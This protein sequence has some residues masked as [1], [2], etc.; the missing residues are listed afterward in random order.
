M[1]V[2]TVLLLSCLALGAAVAPATDYYVSPDGDDAH[3]GL[4]LATAKKTIQVAV[5]A[6]ADGDV[7][8]VNDGT[9]VLAAAIS[10]AKPLT[11]V[12]INGRDAVFIDG[13]ND[14]RC[15]NVT[16]PG[17]VVEG[18]TICHGQDAAFLSGIGGVNNKGIIRDCA[19]ISNNA[20]L[21]LGGI[22]NAGRMT[23]CLVYTNTGLLIGGVAN[24][25]EGVMADCV[26]SGNYAGVA[27][28]LS[29]D[30]LVSNCVVTANNSVSSGGGVMNNASGLV[31]DSRI[32]GNTAA[33]SAGGV[34]NIGG[35]LSGCNIH[36]NA[37]PEG[38]GLVNTNGGTIESCTISYNAALTNGGGALNSG[39]I[40]KCAVIGNTAPEYGGGIHNLPEG[41]IY[42]CTVI[43]NTAII[44]EI[45]FTGGGGIFNEAGEVWYCRA[46]Y[47]EAT[48]GAG[49]YNY[50]GLV[51]YC[52]AEY[53]SGGVGGGVYSEGVNARVW[54]CGLRYNRAI[55]IEGIGGGAYCDENT[56]I[57]NCLAVGNEA[58]GGGGLVNWGIAY[59]CT[60]I[61]NQALSLGGGMVNLNLAWNCIV[62]DNAAPMEVDYYDDEVGLIAYSCLPEPVAGDGNIT[63]DPG[64]INPGGGVGLDHVYGD[65]RLAAGSPCIDAG[66]TAGWMLEPEA[67]DLDGNPRIIYGKPDIGAF[68][69]FAPPTVVTAS[70]GLYAGYVR[71]TWNA[72]DPAPASYEVWRAGTNDPNQSARLAAAAGLSYDDT[73]AQPGALYYYWVR[74]VMAGLGPFSVSD[75][76]W[77]IIPAPAA[78]AASDGLF[79]DSVRL[80]WAEAPGA[81]GY[82]VYRGTTPEFIQAVEIAAPTLAAYADVSAA[83]G[84]SYYYWVCAVGAFATSE[85]SAPD[86]GWRRSM[87][88]TQN[89]WGDFDGD[90]LMDLAI[91][92]PQ[93]GFWQILL[94]GSNYAATSMQL[95]GPGSVPVT[96]DFNGDGRTDPAVYRESD[97]EWAVFMSNG[98]LWNLV[99]CI[100]GGEGWQAAPSD[101]DGDGKTDPVIYSRNS[102]QWRAMLSGAG[103]AMAETVLGG[104]GWQAAPADFDGDGKA[105]PAV[106]RDADGAW[107]A[108][109]SGAGYTPAAAS[110]GGAGWQAVPADY[111]GDYKADPGIYNIH[112][113]AWQALLS[114]AGYTPAGTVF[115]GE[116][117][118]P[119]PADYD[120]D[121]KADLVVFHAITG[122]WRALLSGAGYAETGAVFGGPG[123]QPLR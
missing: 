81:A 92:N 103:Y 59:N 55:K 102:G 96:G 61:G 19:I 16:H 109:L 101:F 31:C 65:Y 42:D 87:A 71:I 47:N 104:A 12:G 89:A 10:L 37:A 14:V 115:G 119:L 66:Q 79:T 99:T 46:A 41:W 70:D 74:P 110:F 18:L 35:M 36:D 30:G 24:S 38:A 9:Y 22:A 120:G 50:D 94:S 7:V 39:I 90:G 53:N 40:A 83:P 3:D 17:A 97:G 52:L 67:T 51:N 32:A 69:Y 13:N 34:Y 113:G 2:K 63:A 77:R 45:G 25:A 118:L 1:N 21:G 20:A 4:S 106:Y 121:G 23:G 80:T 122:Q 72:S 76:G 27:A 116:Y 117:W 107:S 108:M 112:S 48:L 123:W 95:G 86:T 73:S 114:G 26:V 5:N 105:D 54:N 78:L 82:K 49:I 28:G 44:E 98:A 8:H 75:S 84:M 85:P 11:L 58:I 56:D 100:F 29:N 6:A 93:T 111:D 57:R 91:Y 60:V 62:R 43:S 33:A 15:M 88:A 68:E 64:L